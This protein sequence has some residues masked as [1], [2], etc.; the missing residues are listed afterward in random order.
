MP[1][2]SIDAYKAAEPWGGFKSVVGLSG[3]APTKCATPTI[4]IVDGKLSYSC[5]TDGVT[6][7]TSYNYGSGGSSVDGA[8][9]I[10]VGTTTAHVSVYATKDGCLDSDVATADVELSV[11][12]KGDVNQDG[13][14]SITDAVSVVNIILGQ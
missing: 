12:T 1:D 5:E 13:V 8:E 6:F 2:A 4:K 10:L 14:V 11:G 3:T 9:V 7:K